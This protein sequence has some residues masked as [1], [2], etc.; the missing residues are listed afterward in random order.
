M[1]RIRGKR[2]FDVVVASIALALL[3]PIMALTGL[4]IR[5]NSPGP[6]LYKAPRVG[7]DGR[8]FTM[9]KFRTMYTAP[10]SGG[11]F[12]ASFTTGLNDPR[13]TPV[14]VH[15]RRYKIDE[16]PQLWNVLRGEMSLVGPR[17][18]VSE[19]VA[20]YTPAEREI[21]SVRPGITDLSSLRFADLA[22]VVGESADPHAVFMERVFATKNALRLQYVREASWRLDLSIL[23]RTA[24][25]VV[26]LNG[27]GLPTG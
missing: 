23:A 2:A 13:V 10:P 18:E 24:G 7:R 15:L 26:G 1:S 25:A 16:L 21:L 17:P 20:L 14:G 4:A 6:A 3:S 8:M 9:L 11:N 27:R 5:R 22:S 19:C 12:T